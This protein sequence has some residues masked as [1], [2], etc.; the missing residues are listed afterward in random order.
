MPFCDG[1]RN[2]VKKT[3]K[4][5]SECGFRL[6]QDPPEVSG[7]DAD[8]HKVD[9]R[10]REHSR[11]EPFWSILKNGLRHTFYDNDERLSKGRKR[12][13]IFLGLVI[14]ALIAWMAA[15]GL[16]SVS[17]KVGSN[18]SQE[19]GCMSFEPAE[20]LSVLKARFY[21]DEN[22][23]N[24]LVMNKMDIPVR[25][26]KIVKTYEFR[27]DARGESEEEAVGMT[28]PPE[29]TLNLTFRVSEKPY[30][31][32]LYFDGCLSKKILKYEVTTS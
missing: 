18:E 29:Q 31:I 3:D 16:D 14:I 2:L 5:C 22:L 15:P 17:L 21:A 8:L 26:E 20:Q 32:G 30:I 28:I 4:Y 13:N 9:W 12:L 23:F 7:K 6:E 11:K 25:L 27:P 24:T 19:E 10:K 1:C